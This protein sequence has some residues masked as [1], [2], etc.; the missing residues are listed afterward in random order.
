[1]PEKTDVGLDAVLQDVYAVISG[2]AGAPRDWK[3]HASLF[4]RGARLI[5]VHPQSV[6][7][8]R[9]ESLT[10]TQYRR[11]RET[12]L[13]GNGFVERE[14]A[15]TTELRGQIAHVFSEFEGHTTA[16]PRR[17]VHGWNSIQLV[18]TRDGWRVVTLLWVATAIARRVHSKSAVS[19]RT[20]THSNSDQSFVEVRR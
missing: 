7:R 12:F 18:R 19:R 14:T 9:I 8:V 15:R 10:P 13:V 5:I 1:M 2:P 11:S 20:H 3:R 17:S 4:V 16:K 6:G